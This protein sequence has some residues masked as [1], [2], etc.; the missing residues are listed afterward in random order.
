M[1]NHIQCPFY[2]CSSLKKAEYEV[3]IESLLKKAT[4]LDH[5]LSP[6][7]DKFV[8]DTQVSNIPF[9]IIDNKCQ[10]QE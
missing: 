7:D 1:I 2:I 5:T 3:L 10:Q 9:I 8:P 6:C 4:V